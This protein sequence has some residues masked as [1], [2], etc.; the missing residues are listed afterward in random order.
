MAS[1]VESYIATRCS[2]KEAA[3]VGWFGGSCMETSMVGTFK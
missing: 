2:M 3:R 1:V